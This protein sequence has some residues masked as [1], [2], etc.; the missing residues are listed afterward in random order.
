MQ[1]RLVLSQQGFYLG[2]SV[3]L[4][5]GILSASSWPGGGYGTPIL[6]LLGAGMALA[7]R[8]WHRRL[9]RAARRHSSSL[10]L[11]GYP[12]DLLRDPRFISRRRH[13]A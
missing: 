4:A 12:L 6:T 1:E 7:A 11:G 5:A 3:M 8:L 13:V 9:G 10:D 2:L